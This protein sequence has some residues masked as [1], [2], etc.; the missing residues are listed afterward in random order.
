[1]ATNILTLGG[2][3]MRKILLGLTIVGLVACGPKT[4]KVSVISGDDGSDGLDGSSCST[5]QLEN[6]AK[7]TCGDGSFS[8]LFNGS[9]EGS[10]SNGEDGSSCSVEATKLGAIISCTDGSSASILNGQAGDQG[11]NGQGCEL[12]EIK[13]GALI[14]CGEES[15]AIYNGSDIEGSASEVNVYTYNSGCQEVLDLGLFIKYNGTNA[16]LYNNDECS[17]SKIIQVNDGES[18][19]IADA[20]LG[21]KSKNTF[22]VIDFGGQEE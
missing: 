22:K 6:G 5:Q 13:N 1:M 7:I 21:V 14:T 8:Y 2:E 9:S 17:G 11:D 18:Y 16:S 3:I 19:W 10:G 20:L 4:E 15:V 12:E